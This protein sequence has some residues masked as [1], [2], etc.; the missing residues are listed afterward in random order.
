MYHSIIIIISII[1]FS[2]G[3]LI[4]NANKGW[5]NHLLPLLDKAQ[6]LPR[7]NLAVAGAEDE[8][9]L[10]ACLEGYKRG[11]VQPILI[12]DKTLIHDRAKHGYVDI[13]NFEIIDIADS[14]LAALKG[15]ELVYE[16]KA[17][18]L[19]K[20]AVSASDYLSAISS[21]K[22]PIR[23]GRPLSHVEITEIE[24]I[25]QMLL[26]TDGAVN[27]FPTLEEKVHIISNA[28]EIAKGLGIKEPKVA[29]LSATELVNPKLQT[30]LDAQELVKMNENG[31]I[32]G[33]I[34]E[35]PL[36]LDIAISREA[37]LTKLAFYKKIRGDADILLFPNIESHS[38]AW[39]FVIHTTRHM[40]AHMLV[41]AKIPIIMTGRA[42]DI[43][44]YIH[45]MGIGSLLCDY[46]KKVGY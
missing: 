11:Y 39:K 15:V 17:D 45:S 25:E 12:G 16:G 30:T 9:I 8:L 6:S 24:G 44:S 2:I 21:D 40:A 20:G 3:K 33:C 37:S 10:K 43:H 32:R 7:R 46:F 27:L 42:D 18:I 14:K 41:G 19:M 34:I 13:S 22:F 38:I 31:Y 4:D 26:M 28:V 23:T 35:G 5:S 29:V 36:S 1:Q